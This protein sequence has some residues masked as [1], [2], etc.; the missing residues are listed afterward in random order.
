MPGTILL[1]SRYYQEIAPQDEALD[2]GRIVKL[3]DRCT[4][5]GALAEQFGLE[6]CVKIQETSDCDPDARGI[7]IYARGVGLVQDEALQLVR[8]HSAPLND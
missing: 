3:D 1:G 5:L 4:A 2:K 8:F 7:K 6:G